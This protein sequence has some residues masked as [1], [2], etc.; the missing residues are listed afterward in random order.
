[1]SV[2]T[3]AMTA[4]QFDATLN[5]LGI[6]VY[7]SAKAR[8][9]SLRHADSGGYPDPGELAADHWNETNGDRCTHVYSRRP[10]A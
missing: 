6:S 1:M 3:A 2:R 10:H 7:A 9:I 8:D 5:Q 4:R